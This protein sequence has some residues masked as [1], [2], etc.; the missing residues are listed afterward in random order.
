[1]L[2]KIA[3]NPGCTGRSVEAVL[4]RS[5]NSQLFALPPVGPLER[6][7]SYWRYRPFGLLERFVSYWRYRPFGLLERKV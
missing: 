4:T 2:A 7:V 1:M 6:F 3:V 5:G